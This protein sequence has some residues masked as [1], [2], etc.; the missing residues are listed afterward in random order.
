ML[1]SRLAQ[2]IGDENVTNTLLKELLARFPGVATGDSLRN[3]IMSRIVGDW[4][5]NRTLESLILYL[6]VCQ[7][8]VDT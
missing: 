3:R 5:E 6:A 8:D 2:A 7:E 1:A 4:F